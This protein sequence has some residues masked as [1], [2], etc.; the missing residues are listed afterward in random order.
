MQITFIDKT[1]RNNIIQNLKDFNSQSLTTRA[2]EG[3]QSVSMIPVI[4]KA[5]DLLADDIVDL[6]TENEPLKN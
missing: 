6:S 2:K 4:K 1:I 5:F 3:E